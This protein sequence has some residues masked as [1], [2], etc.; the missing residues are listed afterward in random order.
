MGMTA[1]RGCGKE[2]HDSAR[3]CPQC[4]AVQGPPNAVKGW[5]W[6]AFLLN[7]IWAIGNN[8]WIGLL[9]FIPA[10][11]LIMAL[12]LDSRDASGHGKTNSGMTSN[13]STASSESGRSGEWRF[14]SERS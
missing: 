1:C 13:T 8:T 7:G 11:G 12:I 14:M 5:S 4:G 2:L 3:V 9:A 10:L 6:G